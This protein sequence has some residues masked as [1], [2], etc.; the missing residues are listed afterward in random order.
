MATMRRK[1]REIGPLF[2]LPTV[3]GWQARCSC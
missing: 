1:I 2:I 3:G